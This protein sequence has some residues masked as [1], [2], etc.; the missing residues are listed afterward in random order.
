MAT[1]AFLAPYM[2]RGGTPQRYVDMDV[3]TD[4]DRVWSPLGREFGPLVRFLWEDGDEVFEPGRAM[5]QRLKDALD[6]SCKAHWE[7]H[8]SWRHNMGPDDKP[9]TEIEVRET[10]QAGDQTEP[11]FVILFETTVDRDRA[12]YAIDEAV[13]PPTDGTH[14][15]H[16][17][18]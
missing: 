2:S 12:A 7:I 8:R 17:L 4:K 1:D 13:K 10:V 9:P 5:A 16:K 15:S 6:Q 14:R 11:W 18:H 3:V